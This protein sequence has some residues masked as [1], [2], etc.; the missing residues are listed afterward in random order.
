MLNTDKSTTMM[1]EFQ[2][3][4]LKDKIRSLEFQ[5]EI[6]NLQIEHEKYMRGEYERLFKEA[7]QELKK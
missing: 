7:A 3:F 1:T 2:I 5:L 4:D 6:A